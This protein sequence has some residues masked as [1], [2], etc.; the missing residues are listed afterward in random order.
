MAL[1]FTLLDIILII[2]A[3]VLKK[4]FHNIGFIYN[5]MYKVNILNFY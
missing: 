4:K 1:G 5:Y 3:I 2:S